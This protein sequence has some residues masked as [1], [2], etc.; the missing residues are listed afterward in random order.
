MAL[1]SVVVYMIISVLLLACLLS[2]EV[3]SLC[4]Q[5]DLSDLPPKL[6]LHHLSSPL[7]FWPKRAG[8]CVCLFF[9]C[10]QEECVCVSTFGTIVLK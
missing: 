9:L 10:L 5:L 6:K 1:D 2:G 8:V 4:E 3:F 7:G